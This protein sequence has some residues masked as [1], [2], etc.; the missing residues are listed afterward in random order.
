MNL[1]QAES[2]PTTNLTTVVPATYEYI[3][4]C[5]GK[6][7]SKNTNFKTFKNAQTKYL[8]TWRGRDKQ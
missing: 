1:Q 7:I 6:V 3:V 8:T 5:K 2:E 4:N